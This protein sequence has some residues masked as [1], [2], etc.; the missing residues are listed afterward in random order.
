M[1]P[2]IKI[3][4]FILKKE[5]FFSL[6]WELLGYTLTNFS[7]YHTPLLIIV[8]MLHIT[9]PIPV[10]LITGS[11]YVLTSLLQFPLPTTF[12]SGNHNLISFSFFFSFLFFFINLFTYFYILAVFGLCCCARA[13]SSC[14]ERG[15][16]FVALRGL[17][18]AVASLAVEHGLYARQLQ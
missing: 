15:L 11:L 9:S 12:A 13:F 17:L 16:L 5:I 7:V 6:W 1:Q 10:Y 14:S 3:N 4:K 2:K 18:I 8:I